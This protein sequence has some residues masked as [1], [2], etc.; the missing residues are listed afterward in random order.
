MGLNLKLVSAEFGNPHSGHTFKFAFYVDESRERCGEI[1]VAIP[2][3]TPSAEWVDLA[4]KIVHALLLTI[5]PTPETPYT[6]I[7]PR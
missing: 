5:P 6:P 3:A 7:T 4:F 2:F 1:S